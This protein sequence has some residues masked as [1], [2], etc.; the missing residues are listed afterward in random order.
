MDVAVKR[1]DSKHDG[2]GGGGGGNEDVQDPISAS[3]LQVMMRTVGCSPCAGPG[4]GCSLLP[5]M[6]PLAAMRH[7]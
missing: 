6:R 3:A 5:A 1:D 7:R 4:H 2:G